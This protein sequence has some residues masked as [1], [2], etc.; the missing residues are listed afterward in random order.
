MGQEGWGSFKETWTGYL[1]KKGEVL[2]GG[3][4]RTKDFHIEAKG[5]F[6][7]SGSGRL[8]VA[9]TVQHSG[10]AHPTTVSTSNREIYLSLPTKACLILN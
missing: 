8:K 2:G 7:L 5:F 6:S 10:S 4:V 1:C 3:D 9:Q